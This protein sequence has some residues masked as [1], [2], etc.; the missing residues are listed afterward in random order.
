MDTSDFVAW[1]ENAFEVQALTENREAVRRKYPGCVSDQAG[2]E[3]IMLL[4]GKGNVKGRER[5]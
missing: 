1:R 5:S 2:L 3:D 4:Y